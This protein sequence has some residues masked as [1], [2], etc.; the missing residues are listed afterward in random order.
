[1]KILK[2]SLPFKFVSTPHFVQYNKFKINVIYSIK[3]F[4]LVTAVVSMASLIYQ[5][6]CFKREKNL[7]LNIIKQPSILESQFA[8]YIM[9]LFRSLLNKNTDN[10]NDKQNKPLQFGQYYSNWSPF[11]PYNFKPTDMDLRETTH[12]YYS[13]IG[14][15]EKTCKLYLMDKH[16]DTKYKDKFF[17]AD[18]APHGLILEFNYLR[19]GILN[20][21]NDISNNPTLDNKNEF[22]KL[23]E[24]NRNSKNFKFIMSIGGWSEAKSFHKLAKSDEY[25]DNF[26]NSCVDVLMA[27]GF[28]G[29]DIDWEYPKNKKEYQTYVTIFKRLREKLDLLEKQIFGNNHIKNS[30]WFHLSTAIPCD[31][32]VLENLRLKEIEPFIDGFNLMAYDLSGEW[33]PKTAYQSNLYSYGSNDNE[34][35]DIDSVVSYLIKELEIESTK[36]ILGIPLYGR[37]FTNVKAKNEREVIGAEF[38][39]VD[40][41]FDKNSPGV[42]PTNEIYKLKDYTFFHDQKA[43]SSYLYNAKKKHLIVFDDYL[44]IKTKGEYIHQK[45]LGGGFFWEANGDILV[46]KHSTL[47]FALSDYNKLYFDKS[48]LKSIW[49]TKSM[50]QYYN[51]QVTLFQ[52]S[53]LSKQ[54]KK[55]AEMLNL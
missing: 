27:N 9:H 45:A 2:L 35:G 4:I 20:I 14:I 7:N 3:F 24:A 26:V 51:E 50:Q 46:K 13:F 16:A 30:R 22:S 18:K 47:S 38:K 8:P 6:V 10:I 40:D 11:K 37:S 32:D 19:H 33:S 23:K 55:I 49:T 36:I 5:I 31:K 53:I 54:S 48:N 28:D 43:V 1:M 39:G 29:V 25:L 42:W 17:I 12:I 52:D 15:D 21:H 41:W 34:N 44:S